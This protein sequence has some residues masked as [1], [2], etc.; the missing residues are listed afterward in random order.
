MTERHKWQFI[1]NLEELE[2]SKRPIQAITY[3]S[4]RDNFLREKKRRASSLMML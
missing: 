4:A 3:H 2:H 1:N